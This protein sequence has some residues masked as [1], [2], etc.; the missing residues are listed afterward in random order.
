MGMK[1]SQGL[2]RAIIAVAVAV[3]AACG[4]AEREKEMHAALRAVAG[5]ARPAYAAHD[6]EG[7]KLWKMTQAFYEKRSHAA[8]WVEGAKPG[9]QMDELIAALRDSTNEGLDPE[10][11]TVSMLEAR[12]AEASKGFL[13]DKGF[14]PREAG[15]LDVWLTY[16]YMKYAS[17]IADGLSDLSHADPA[18][19]I[20]PEKFDPQAHLEKALA[21]GTIEASLAELTPR[22]PEYQRLRELL[23]RYKEQQKQGGWPRVPA[24][25][26]KPGQKSPHVAALAKR[27]AASG[28]YDG[29]VPSDATASPYTPQLQEAVKVFQRRH[30]LT[31]DGAIGPEVVAA[32]NIPLEHRINQIAMNMERWRWLPRDLGDRFMLV[33]IPEMRL[34]VFDNDKVSLTMRVVVG[35]QDTPTPIFNDEMTHLVFSPYWNVPDSIAQGETLPAV[36]NDPGFLQR[37]NMEV[38]DKAGNVVDPSS[39]DLND[40][41]AYRFRQKPG[42]DNSLGLVKFMFPNQFNVYLHDTPADSLFERAAR[43]FSHG[44]VRVEDPVALAQYVLRDQPE[45]DE[46]RIRDAMEAGTEKH[47]KLKSPIPVFLGYWT[48]RVRPD[49]TVQFRKDVYEIDGKLQARL[50][51]RLARLRRSGEAAAAA[52]TV[53]TDDV[54]KKPAKKQPARKEPRQPAAEKK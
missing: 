20:K 29:S 18:W 16:L 28:D 15:A 6:P 49:N 50:N 5:G 27:L 14:D 17:D 36:I 13:T 1:L 12:R 37:T 53:G 23:V 47:V 41:T 43:S 39:V 9:D 32:L 24:V 44:C 2:T 42:A 26:L 52:T 3:C 21:D 7:N 34:D 8:A 19:K 38:V 54:E 45:W 46:D 33:N 51:D 25:K 4:G 48:A 11:Y 10:L 30:G 35:K 22:V 31:D 40:P